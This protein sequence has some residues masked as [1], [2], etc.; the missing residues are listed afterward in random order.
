MSENNFSSTGSGSPT[1]VFSIWQLV[2]RVYKLP[3][4]GTRAFAALSLFTTFKQV[5][6]TSCYR[7]IFFYVLRDV[8]QL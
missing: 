8:V 2:R 3:E 7:A 4:M 1:L 5:L 6:P